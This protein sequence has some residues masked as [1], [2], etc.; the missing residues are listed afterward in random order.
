MIVIALLAASSMTPQDARGRILGRV[1][2][3]SGAPI[4]RAPIEVTEDSTHVKLGATTN[5]A[6]AYE[7]LY[8]IPGN[9]TLAVSAPGFKSYE[10][11]NIEVRVADRIT[12]DV[13]LSVG[14]VN[15]SV[16]V[17]GQ[18][19]LVDTASA[20][21]GQVTDKRR[22]VEMPL[23]GGNSLTLAQFAPGII[24]LDQPNHPSLGIGAIDQVSN[25]AVNGTRNGNVEFTVDGAPS[26]TGTT[27]SFSPPTEMVS[28]VKVQTATYDASTGRVPGGNVN[29]V[30]RTGAN[31]FHGNVQWFHTNQH[32]EGLTLFSRQFLYDPS[33]GPITAEKRAQVN[34]LNILNRYSGTIS[35]PGFC[36]NSTMAITARSGC[37]AAKV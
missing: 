13:T 16:T 22:I 36:P 34:P 5:E 30:L 1:L 10:R 14:Q 4:P 3:P 26:M 31:Q 6:G 18:T 15:E 12:L 33:S 7:F 23:P 19:A 21:M 37:S 35:G 17:S 24:Y 8:L 27:V 28:E 11:T 29:I 20:N 2:D 25:L 9:Y 32:L